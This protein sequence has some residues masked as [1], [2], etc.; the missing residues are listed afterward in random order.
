MGVTIHYKLGQDVKWVKPML[1]DAEKVASYTGR[2]AKEDKVNFEIKRISDNKLIVNIGN[3]ESL[4]FSFKPMSEYKK[5]GEKS[6]NYQNEVLKDLVSLDDDNMAWTAEFV[7]TQFCDN[8][9]EH[10]WVAEL[11]RFVAGRCRVA[12]VYDEG[13]YYHSAIVE[14]AKNAINENGALIGKVANQLKD[15]GYDDV[16]VAEMGIR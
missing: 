13:D 12:D 16:R 10:V 9:E 14:D 8:L 15:I 6:W 5:L 2:K 11:I 1:D 3:C 4:V 7:K